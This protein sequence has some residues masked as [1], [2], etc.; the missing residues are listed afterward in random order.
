ME[1]NSMPDRY[2]GKCEKL[3]DELGQSPWCNY[4]RK[5][6]CPTC[7]REHDKEQCKIE[8]DLKKSQ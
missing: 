4:C 3:I 8:Q 5:I 2:C 7:E 6:F 1:V